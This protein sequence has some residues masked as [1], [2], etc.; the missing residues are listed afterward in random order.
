MKY[1][2]SYDIVSNKRRT[3]ISKTLEQMG[4]RE[5]KSLF[6]CDLTEQEVEEVKKALLPLV[7]TKEDSL[8]VFPVCE[9]CYAETFYLGE[10]LDL[11]KEN[12]II[13]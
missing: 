5:Q 6:A 7:N 12:Y 10:R 1:I 3:K 4:F 9:R 13:L 11:F 2:F 8:A